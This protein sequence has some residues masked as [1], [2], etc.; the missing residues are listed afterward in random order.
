VKAVDRRR[1]TS[2][3][4]ET[5]A[6]NE[7]A[8]MSFLREYASEKNVVQPIQISQDPHRFYIVM[9]LVEGGNLASYLS[10]ERMGEEQVQ[11]LAK[12]LLE[13]LAELHSFGIGHFNLQPENVLL[14]PD[15]QVS[16]C[17]F[18]NAAFVE[19]KGSIRRQ[20]NL[21]Y[22]SPEELLKRP[23]LA[24]D[25]WSV[26]VILYYSF[27]G[28]LPFDDSS[29]QKLKGKIF[30]YSYDFSSREWDLVSRSAKQFLSSLLHPDPQI[31]MTA[32]EALG[33]SWLSSSQP[34]RSLV[35]R[36]RR[37]RLV[38]HVWGRLKKRPQKDSN[39]LR[40][41]STISSSSSHL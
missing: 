38:D 17:D 18:G 11:S 12:S 25:M 32:K 35:K 23:G 31:R 26:G 8:M 30:G 3:Q 9:N 19:E 6:L 39:D 24:S 21:A 36:R 15:F 5:A 10:Q 14:G 40:T 2:A 16:L 28:H 22:A 33:H 27:C 20:S 34:N 37:V 29:K 7:I 13:S 1:F 41:V 4:D